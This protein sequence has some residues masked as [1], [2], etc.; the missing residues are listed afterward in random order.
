MNSHIKWAFEM[1]KGVMASAMY[2][3]YIAPAYMDELFF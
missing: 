3:K 2:Q 1:L